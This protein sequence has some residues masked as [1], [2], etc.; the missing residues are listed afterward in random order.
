MK[1]FGAL[2]IIF[3]LNINLFSQSE[4]KTFVK[5]INLEGIQVVNLALN[6]NVEIQTWQNPTMRIMVNVSLEYGN[7]AI[8]KSLVQ[9]KRYFLNSEINHSEME[10]FA[11]G[12]AKEVSLRGTTLKENISYVV[13][14]PEAVAV[15]V[16]EEAMTATP[17]LAISK[18]K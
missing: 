17:D 5:G 13:F 12:L 18:L 4:E 6:G 9:A 16:K 15:N 10:I 14:A 3:C 11:P 8:L 7:N 2:V 1:I